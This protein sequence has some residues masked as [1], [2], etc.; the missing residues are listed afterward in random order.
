MIYFFLG[1]LQRNRSDRHQAIL[2]CSVHCAGCSYVVAL[3]T[4]LGLLLWSSIDK[5]AYDAAIHGGDDQT[6]F[7][8]NVFCVISVVSLIW[9]VLCCCTF[10]I[11][12]N[13]CDSRR[14]A[15]DID[16]LCEGEE[17]AC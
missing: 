9:F 4:Y 14:F 5:T 13:C 1:E 3:L 10:T 15:G 8:L 12:D 7:V 6:L 2:C 11:S 17:E 16:P